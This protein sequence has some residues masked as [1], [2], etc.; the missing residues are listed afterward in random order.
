MPKFVRA[1]PPLDDSEARKVGRLVGAPDMDLDDPSLNTGP[2]AA[3]LCIP[4]KERSTSY[5]DLENSAGA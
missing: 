5:F 2:T 1:R 3:A 4:F